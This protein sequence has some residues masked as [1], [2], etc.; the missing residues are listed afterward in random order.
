MESL[1]EIMADA[2]RPNLIDHMKPVA[3]KSEIGVIKTQLQAAYNTMIEYS[4]RA[5]KN[6]EQSALKEYWLGKAEAYETA[7]EFIYTHSVIMGVYLESKTT[8][9]TKF[10]REERRQD[11]I[12]ETSDYDH[13]D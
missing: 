5:F 1:F 9:L 12:I 10:N 13:A 11:E 2:V 8:E 6:Q 4:D 7:S 3:T